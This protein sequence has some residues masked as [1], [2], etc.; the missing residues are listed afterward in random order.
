M[1][2]RKL[3]LVQ[4]IL[5]SALAIFLTGILIFGISGGG[6][7]WNREMAVQKQ[8]TISL[9]GIEKIK[10]DFSSENIVIT[11]TDDDEIRIV[12]SANRNLRDR[13]KFSTSRDGAILD[14]SQGQNRMVI[15]IFGMSMNRKVELFIPRSYA[16]SLE[17]ELD[18][19]NV[20][21][22]DDV[23]VKDFSSSIDSGNFEAGTL[24][25]AGEASIET[26]SGN[27]RIASMD[28]L[29]Y[30]I[31]V[32]SG[33][34]RI[35]YLKGSGEIKGTSGNI[36]VGRLDIIE[37]ADVRTTSGNIELIMPRALNFEFEGYTASGNINTDF[38]IM[39]QT[40]KKHASGK[41]GV[42]PYV[43]LNAEVTS[44]NINISL[45]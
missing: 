10:M 13:E 43:K 42:E 25:V 20:I 37:Y 19:G 1:D 24:K 14:I 9:G 5:W 8:E 23:A 30:N 36:K 32:S 26:D 7:S 39:Y 12:E 3:N 29:A 27:V 16:E 2:S 38:E 33:N 18:S 28:S 22:S 15:G 4:I 35:D 34:I 31:K 11:P 40:D 45:E 17:L 41:V 44:G 21:F 6:T